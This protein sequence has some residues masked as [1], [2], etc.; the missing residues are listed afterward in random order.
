MA[1][2][3]EFVPTERAS[4]QLV[5]FSGNDMVVIEELIENMLQEFEGKKVGYLSVLSGYA[6]VLFSLL[7]RKL[8]GEGKKKGE[9]G[10][11]ITP[12]VIEYINKHCNEKLSLEELAQRCF[13]NPTYF[14]HAFKKYCGKN[15]SQYIKERRIS[16]A[17][18]LLEATDMS[19][20]KIG[21]N[22]GYDDK[23]FFYKVFKE[24]TGKTPASYREEIQKKST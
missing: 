23:A 12:D 24:I 16:N 18:E 3:S 8:V 15:L 9:V 4:V 20:G 11:K 17:I 14:S 22:V 2:F 5:H 21:V 10:T 19:I 6:R 7:L 13:Y 1:M